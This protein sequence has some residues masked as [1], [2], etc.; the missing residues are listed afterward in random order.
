MQTP[1]PTA[2]ETE[3]RP[4]LLLAIYSWDLLLA[5]LALVGAFTAFGGAAAVGN[6]TVSV[7]VGEQVLAGFSSA[8]RAAL[9]IIIATLLTRR[10]RWVRWMQIGAYLVA[11]LLGGLSVLLEAVLPGHGLAAG[12]I[13]SAALV[14]LID[15]I[16]IVVLTGPKIAAWYTVTARPPKYLTCTL[17]F[18]LGSG[19]V[20]IVF[21][22]LR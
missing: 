6:R 1:A 14:L 19:L 9:L 21:Q 13:L 22:A 17:A 11:I 12:Y 4:A 3:Q 7:S 10:Q 5:L 15:V 2:A 8:S 18:W 20:L 16:A